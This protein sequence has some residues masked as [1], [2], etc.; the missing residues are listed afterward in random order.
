MERQQI[1]PSREHDSKKDDVPAYLNNLQVDPDM[2][3]YERDKQK[4]PGP[5]FFWRVIWPEGGKL[6]QGRVNFIAMVYLSAPTKQAALQEF[7]RWAELRMQDIPF[8]VIEQV[9]STDIP[10]CPHPCP[11][12]NGEAIEGRWSYL[13]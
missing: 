1:Q 8:P 4:L 11:E 9:D 2:E 7:Q 12:H 6:D 13:T 3:W 10:T 5:S